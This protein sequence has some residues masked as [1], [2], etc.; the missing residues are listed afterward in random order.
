MM[1]RTYLVKKMS[2]EMSTALKVHSNQTSRKVFKI[3]RF[4]NTNTPGDGIAFAEEICKFEDDLD[5]NNVT[6]KLVNKATK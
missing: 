3:N 2:V 4:Q 6:Y 1:L 5:V